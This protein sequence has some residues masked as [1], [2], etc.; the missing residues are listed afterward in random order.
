MAEEN[1]AQWTHEEA[2][3]EYRIGSEERGVRIVGR[4]EKAAN[5]AGEEAVDSEIV[6]FHHIADDAGPDDPLAV[7]MDF[8]WRC[9]LCAF[10][11]GTP[12]PTEAV[13]DAPVHTPDLPSR[14]ETKRPLGTLYGSEIRAGECSRQSFPRRRDRKSPLETCAANPR[15]GTSAVYTDPA[16]P[17]FRQTP[18]RAMMPA[19]PRGHPHGRRAGPASIGGHPGGRR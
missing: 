6:P 2:D 3:G 14:V 4:K 15:E 18:G 19:T 12:N 17:P 7:V 1:G 13:L 9:R 8:S 5:G 11:D 16:A 10:H